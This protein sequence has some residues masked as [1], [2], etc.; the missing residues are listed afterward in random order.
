M[1]KSVHYSLPVTVEYLDHIESLKYNAIL[2]SASNKSGLSQYHQPMGIKVRK[3]FSGLYDTF[4]CCTASGMEAMSEIQKNIWF[5]SQDSIL[6]NMFIKSEVLWEE[7]DIIIRQDTKY[8]DGQISVLTVEAQRPT[9]FK[10]ILKANNIQSVKI[11]SEYLELESHMGFITIHRIFNNNDSIELEIN[12]S[13]GFVYLKGCQ[14]KVAVTYGKLVLALVGEGRLTQ[15]I[16]PENLIKKIFKNPTQQLS[17][18]YENNGERITLIPLFRVEEEEYSVYFDLNN[19]NLISEF[20]FAK[21][22]KE[23]YNS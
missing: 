16:N 2:N 18:C 14:D 6:L 22:G 5:K 1:P 20:K 15:G 23:A 3:K 7:K 11:N 21:D 17:F 4:W 13:L 10:L 12:A 19:S 9:E 8:P